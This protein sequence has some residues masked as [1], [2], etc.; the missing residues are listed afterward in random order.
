MN[1][2][3]ALKRLFDRSPVA[4]LAPVGHGRT[5][6]TTRAA[7]VIA[8]ALVGSAV[9]GLAQTAALAAPTSPLTLVG[10]FAPRAA[11]SMCSLLTPRLASQ[12]MPGG[13][14][15]IPGWDTASDCS[16]ETAEEYGEPHAPP[17]VGQVEL[18][19]FVSSALA[20]ST[21]SQWK[22]EARGHAGFSVQNISGLGD[23]AACEQFTDHGRPAQSWVMVV[24]GAR[25]FLLNLNGDPQPVGCSAL[26]PL[27][28][29][30]EARAR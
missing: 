14:Y 23:S 17:D 8:F 12:V 9:A 27:A 11:P 16:Y 10:A 24:A 13:A 2:A 7:A 22:R 6:R 29:E 3:A 25:S 5:L 19:G 26:V 30:V 4:P 21:V 1:I 20:T 28:R 18:T 15:A